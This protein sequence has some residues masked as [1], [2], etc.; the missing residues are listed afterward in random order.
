MPNRDSIIIYNDN[1][2]E[3][4]GA[5]GRYLGRPV[6]EVEKT[7]FA[8]REIKVKIPI[9]VRE[10]PVFYIH[11]FRDATP[12][13]S[14][15]ELFMA[16]DALKMSSAVKVIDVVPFIPFTRAD[17]KDEPRVSITASLMARL[18]QE[19]GADRVITADLHSGQAQ[20]FYKIPVD[21]LY[22][23]KLIA[24]YIRANGY[25]IGDMVIGSPDAGSMK[26]SLSLAT[27]LGGLELVVL[28]KRRQVDKDGKPIPNL[29]KIYNVIGDVDGKYVLFFDDMIDT[30]GTLVESAKAVKNQGALGVFAGATHGI[31]SPK[32][33][34]T[35]EEKLFAEIDR[36]I[37]TDTLP[38][39]PHSKKS[40]VSVAEFF[41]K[42]IDITI[43]GGSL[44]EELF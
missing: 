4:A 8:N 14:Y 20:G 15:V 30:G 5:V 11:G 23:D 44:S 38:Q 7:S 17:R 32:D 26:R 27:H 35:A 43:E 16:N 9:N 36:I 19:S 21:N 31:L 33:G 13:S 24:E 3:F 41:A 2:A 10:H 42:A 6:H 34:V 29:P 28:E 25:P 22:V 39:T 1:A 18:T 37:V 12:M 40:V